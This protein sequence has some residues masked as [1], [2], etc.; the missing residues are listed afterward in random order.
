MGIGIDGNA[1][2]NGHHLEVNLVI[3][4][5]ADQVVGFTNWLTACA[6]RPAGV[7]I[8]PLIGRGEATVAGAMPA[9]A[10]LPLDTAL[11]IASDAAATVAAWLPVLAA[12]PALRVEYTPADDA[13]ALVRRVAICRPHWLIVDEALVA[14]DPAE[15]R[16]LRRL[17]DAAPGLRVLLLSAHVGPAVHERVLRLRLQ[18]ALPANAGADACLAALR[19][20][21]QPRPHAP[22][23]RA[24][25][26]TP[27]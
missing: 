19:G 10:M 4:G 22:R 27:A 9:S 6:P 1:E 26:A 2:Y 13:D 23:A 5:A 7:R 15:L 11:L 18:G 14:G 16:L 17:R 3:S 8:D 12:E 21:P 25:A 24:R 20:T